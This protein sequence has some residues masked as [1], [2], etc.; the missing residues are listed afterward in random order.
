MGQQF[1]VFGDLRNKCIKDY[2]WDPP[3]HVIQCK[4]TVILRKMCFPE[5]GGKSFE[6]DILPY[7]RAGPGWPIL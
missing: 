3:K 2:S 7:C 1:A 5:H 4:K 6:H